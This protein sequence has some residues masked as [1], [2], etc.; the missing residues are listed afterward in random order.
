MAVGALLSAAMLVAAV[1]AWASEDATAPVAAFEP[2]A[3][4]SRE[5]STTAPEE[6]GTVADAPD[7][8]VSVA[9]SVV[10]PMSFGDA[11]VVRAEE[12]DTRLV[13]QGTWVAGA[14]SAASAKGYAY[15]KSAGASM[16]L[17][18]RGTRIAWVAPVGP[19]YGR[20]ETYIDGKLM[21]RVN[22]YA[23]E[24]AHQKVVWQLSGLADTAH[25]L[26]VR[27]TGQKDARST[28][29]I[30]VVDAFDVASDAASAAAIYGARVRAEESDTR[31]V[32]QGTWVAGATSAAS[33]KGYAYSKSAGASMTLHFR[34][35]RI[36]WVAPVGPSYG[37]AETYI[38]GKL[39]NRVNLYAPE[40]AH[41]K[42]V[43]QLSGLA[44]T[45]HTLTVRVTGQKD[46]RSTGTI[47]VVDAFDVV[48]DR[49]KGIAQI[50]KRPVVKHRYPW[51][52]YIVIDKSEFRLHW[53]RDGQLVKSYPVAHGRNGWTPVAVWRIDSKYITDPRSVYGP[54]KMRLY[55][56]TKRADGTYKYVYSSYLIHGTNN[57]SSIGTLASAGCIRMYNK[58]VLE[59]F[60]QVPIGTMVIT[61]E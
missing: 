15:S 18:F 59:L 38:D 21:N 58:D 9:P 41:Q 28:G 42:V 19:S 17:H 31:L 20:A 39:M 55:R 35:T 44:D 30:V 22:L 14:T 26:T 25:T 2:T 61:Q 10:T 3:S 51:R 57:Q 50:H 60:P 56:Q 34:G 24:Y 52:H 32:R 12:S 46:A 47:V 43:W 6:T 49:A 33:A 13:R 11:D 23:P 45:A 7:P 27:V 5:P 37:R 54:R 16:T 1:P 29:A 4:V 36:A 48:A 53:Y 8:T 40:Y